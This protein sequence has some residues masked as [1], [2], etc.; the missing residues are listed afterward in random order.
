[1]KKFLLILLSVLTIATTLWANTT[2]PLNFTALSSEVVV[3]IDEIGNPPSIDLVY[4]T[5]G[6]QSWTP[7]TIKTSITLN[8]GE[9]VYFKAT[10]TNDDFSQSY[11]N[12]Y[13]FILTDEVAAAGNIMSLL[14][15][16][17]QQTTVPEFAFY[18]LFSGCEKLKTAPELPAKTM[19]KNCYLYMFEGCTSLTAAPELPATKLA[20]ACYYAMFEGCT[21]MTTPPT[22]LP[23][24]K[25]AD[26]CYYEMFQECSSLL[27]APT[28]P[29]TQLADNCYLAMFYDCSS[30]TK[31]PALPATTLTENCY[32][33]MFQ[34]CTSLL[35]LPTL[36]ATELAEMCYFSMF[37]GCTS[38]KINETAPGKP[39]IIPANA[40][41]ADNWNSSMF[42][43]T[44]GTF[45]D[46]PQ[47]GVTYYVE[48]DPTTEVE[49]VAEN[50]ELA[51]APNPVRLGEVAQITVEDGSMVEVY[52]MNGQCVWQ[53]CDAAGSVNV[54]GLNE[55]G[56][57]VVKVTKA[58]G[59][60]ETGKLIVR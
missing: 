14:D 29:A 32:F 10:T 2:E 13:K 36:P 5:D 49:V 35:A 58:D 56:V 9:K 39:W 17:M 19:S 21:A 40:I 48:S 15:A 1:M 38:L 46:D 47:T 57:Y 59:R 25:L 12:N 50:I 31:A 37:E 45:T 55:A 60:V 52:N 51:I 54:S 27:T 6:C 43:N 24:T 3:Y 33:Q 11:A 16:T 18:S 41:T 4:S 23:A 22:T 20:D 53:K 44:G 34:G 26:K 7:Y 28:L 8:Q 30:L 42:S